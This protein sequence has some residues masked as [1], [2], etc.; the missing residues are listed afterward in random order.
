MKLIIQIP[1]Y[2]EEKTLLSVL[3]ELPTQIDGVDEIETMIIDDGSSDKTIEVATKFGVDYIV[4]HIGNKGLGNS[5]KSG[6]HKALL[7]GADILVNTDGD[8][9]YPSKFIPD[10]IKPILEGKADFVMGNRQTKKISHFSFLKKF[11][12]WLGSA[13]VRYLSG[14]NIPDSVSGFR[15]YSKEALLKLNVTSDF[16]YA[17]DTLIQAGRKRIKIVDVDITTNKPTRPSRLFKNMWHH[18]YKTTQIMIRVYAMYN[19][20]R[21]FFALG[22]PFL[23]L[24]LLGLSRFMYFYMMNPVDT[25]KIQSLVISGVFLMIAIQFYALGIIGDLIAK[26]RRLIEDDLYLTKKQ[27]YEK[28]KGY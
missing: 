14:T 18:M 21:I 28:N 23:V 19:P 9:Q 27:Y 22:T 13:M 11:F 16:S 2:N 8:N 17:V 15:A 1:C 5:F 12:Q 24:G 26:N 25:G 10:L 20:M 7:E 6:V 3:E 4:K